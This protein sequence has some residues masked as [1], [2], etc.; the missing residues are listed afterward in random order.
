MRIFWLVYWAMVGLGI[1]HVD[2]SGPDSAPAAVGPKSQGD[3][4]LVSQV[5][6][7]KYALAAEV[8]ALI[9]RVGTRSTG[10][11]AR[12]NEPTV[13]ASDGT[14]GTLA[15]EII[16]RA[17]LSGVGHEL[18]PRKVIVDQ[19]SNSLLLLAG[20]NDMEQIKG[21]IS[22]VDVVLAQ[23]L[24]EAVIIELSPNASISPTTLLQKSA[25]LTG[26]S[27]R[28][29]EGDATI[30]SSGARWSPDEQITS[31]AKLVTGAATN[32]ASSRKGEF[33][34][35]G[36]VGGGM[37]VTLAAIARM[38]GVKVLQWPC[39][40]TS[41]GVE[42]QIF[43]ARTIG[44][45]MA[46]FGAA[47]YSCGC[48]SSTEHLQGGTTLGLTPH[49]GSDELVVMDVHQAIEEY[50][51]STTISGIGNVPITARSETREIVAS[52]GQEILV[53]GGRIETIEK[54][55]HLTVPV[56]KDI[57][58]LDALYQKLPARRIQSDML[59][60]VQATV[61]PRPATPEPLRTG[62]RLISPNSAN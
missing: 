31:L 27:A 40:Q 26:G 43:V 42:V 28:P 10:A 1:G 8:A 39:I 14:R 17:G 51:G 5:L 50:A 52:H 49:I 11:G 4:E 58:L 46:Y 53:L 37:D 21:I 25:A 18:G 9:E 47:A 32:I 62:L 13:K 57:A 30:P 22:K 23:L 34:C 41:D 3:S 19:R 56:L 16:R 24:V 55:G 44:P 59:V 61:L 60:L 33:H 15:D 35:L 36:K 38:P 20:R 6:P 54:R 7:I 29:A 45:T 48:P 2:A 12:T